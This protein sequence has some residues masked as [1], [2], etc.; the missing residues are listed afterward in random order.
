MKKETF[1]L[2]VGVIAFAMAL[3][4]LVIILWVLQ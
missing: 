4:I 1:E 2:L 3:P